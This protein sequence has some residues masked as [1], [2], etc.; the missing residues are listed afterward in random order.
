M[1][2]LSKIALLGA[3]AATAL[4][5]GSII[6]FETDGTFNGGFLLEYYYRKVNGQEIPAT[7]GWYAENLDNGFIEPNNY[8]TADIIC[9]KNAAPATSTATVTAGG[10]VAFHWSD[11]PESHKGPIL[12]YVAKYE[13]DEASIDKTALEWVKIDGVGIDIA[14]QEWPTAQLIANNNTWTT[15]VP[16]TLA[17]GKYVFRHEII[18]MHGAGS[19]NGAQNYPLCV[20]IEVTGS[21]TDN[22]VG[23]LGTALYKADDAGI[24]FNP[25]TTLTSYTVPGPALYGSG[26]SGNGGSGSGS[27]SSAPA[28]TSTTA[29]PT[30][31]T[32]AVATSAPTSAAVT[33]ASAAPTKV[34]TTSVVASATAAPTNGCSGAARRRRRHARE[35]NNARKI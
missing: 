6:D 28:A 32:S 31:A 34:A 10:T 26:G 17:A 9:H 29:T 11:W 21:G 19:L 33:S 12:T 2:I 25:Y 1:A 30:V 7:A 24:L 5:H 35:V 23:T 20:N 4:A 14:T 3:F 18:A 8:G 16:S 27:S 15:T 13:G 22:P